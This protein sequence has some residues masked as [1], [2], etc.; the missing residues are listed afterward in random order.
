MLP[1]Y[2]TASIISKN[3]HILSSMV[4]YYFTILFH[5]FNHKKNFRILSAFNMNEMGSHWVLFLMYLNIVLSG[6]EVGRL[7]SKHV[8][9]YNLIIIIASCLDVCCVLTVQNILYKFDMHNGI[10]SLSKKNHQVCCQDCEPIYLSKSLT[11]H[12]LAT[13]PRSWQ[14]E[15][16][17]QS[18]VN[19]HVTLKHSL[20]TYSVV[21]GNAFSCM[22]FSYFF[23]HDRGQYLET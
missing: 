16:N 19:H 3:F 17:N 11:F 6:P 8:A 23:P 15:F 21:G 20:R 2:S 7:R 18:E 22:K 12:F 1:Y 9:K 14:C 5:C 4:P 10:A 13:I